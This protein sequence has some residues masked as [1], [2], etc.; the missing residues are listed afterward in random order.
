MNNSDK[1]APE[2]LKILLVEDSSTSAML[3]HNVLE[4]GDEVH[5]KFFLTHCKTLGEAIESIK[6][7]EF[8]LVLLDLTLPDS[9]GLETLSRIRTAAP[10]MAVVV[11]TATDDESVGLEALQT[12]AQDYLIK[13]E[14]Y[15]KLLKRSISYARERFLIERSLRNARDKSDTANK[16]KSDFLASMSHEFRT[17]MNAILGFG[18]MLTYNKASPLDPTQ[19]EYVDIILRSGEH[20]LDLINDT[21]DLAKIEA[22]MAEIKLEPVNTS[23]LIDE[24]IDLVSPL[25]KN[26]G[27]SINT[28]TK[29]T[30]SAQVLADET[31]LK[32]VLINLFSNGIK[33]NNENGK[34]DISIKQT[35]NDWVRIDVTDTGNGIAEE[36]MEK[37]FV[38][39]E[40]LEAENSEVEG[41]GV[42]LAVT[43]ELVERMGGTIGL[44]STVGKGST[45]WIELPADASKSPA[46]TGENKKPD[47]MDYSAKGY[48]LL[49]VE[50]NPANKM[51]IEKV[52]SRVEGSTFIWAETAE[53][54]I[55]LAQEK[56][57]DIIIMDINL[58]GMNGIE[59]LKIL[60][61]MEETKHIPVIALSANAMPHDI[62]RGMKAG[63]VRYLTKPIDI[64]MFLKSVDGAL[65]TA[66]WSN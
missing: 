45:F 64:N 3:V 35:G 17:P 30:Q 32:Q 46:K 39:F 60:Q 48:S 47:S 33:Y 28:N 43:K 19:Q 57:P 12:G 16:A 51:L 24:C 10:E 66:N 36:N 34:L 59:A 23:K 41:T 14:T 8:D 18:Q 42:G 6:K 11:L 15:P 40:R 61:S 55:K 62:E 20:L 4:G 9:I 56:N 37:V 25:A 5:G 27:I 44:E 13:D 29:E 2:S 50:D 22:G 54:G 58:P 52:I 63:F 21:L 53:D 38:A 26:R 65:K 31:R 7:Q 49:Y 1:S